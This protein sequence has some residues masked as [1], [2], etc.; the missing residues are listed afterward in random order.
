M[1]LGLTQSG[2]TL[3]EAAELCGGELRGGGENTRFYAYSTDS[4]KIAGGELFFALCGEKFDA[5]KFVPEV[6]AAGALCAVVSKPQAENIP[7]ILVNDTR[8]A[9]GAFASG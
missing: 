9:L 8:A 6:I 7:H 3:R 2:L 4:R 5:H 1:Y